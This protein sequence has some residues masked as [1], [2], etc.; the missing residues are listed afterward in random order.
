[1][2]AR[3]RPSGGIRR[4]GA[5][6]VA[7]GEDGHG[8]PSKGKPAA[9]GG[10]PSRGHAGAE[11]RVHGIHA[12]LAVHARRPQAI[13]KLWLVESC[14]PRFRHVLADCARAR[15]GYRLVGGAD[16]DRLTGTS[17]HEGVCMDVLRPEPWPLATLLAQAAARGTCLGLWL[18]GIGNPHNFGAVL[19]S[20]AH[21]DAVVLQPRARAQALSGAACRVAEGGA[22]TV[23][24]VVVD[25]PA[26]A[27]AALRR[28][29]FAILATAVRAG[30]SIHQTDLPERT[31][32]LFGA[33][34]SGLDPALAALADQS[35]TV[36]GSGAVESLNL[37]AAAAV[38]AAEFRR[39]HPLA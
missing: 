23:P 34:R 29:G 7:G 14:L 33:E 37:A 11:L 38:C 26:A 32:L 21:F 15:I 28:A 35:V 4:T 27:F 9:G 24:Q 36:P 1:M 10:R 18:D 13:R 17:R 25:D 3:A 19:R 39:R 16:L 5:R 31:L 22:E 20:A 12:C 30:R 6:A 2:P 8:V